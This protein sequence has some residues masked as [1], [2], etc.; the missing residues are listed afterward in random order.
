VNNAVFTPNGLPNHDPGF[1]ASGIRRIAWMLYLVAI[2]WMYVVAM[3]AVAEAVAPQGTLLG[4]LFTVL[5]WGVLPL[6]IVVYILGTPTRRRAR[7]AA[8]S[9]LVQPDSSGHAAGEAVAPERKET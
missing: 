4:A 7:R 5:G 3:V 1:F 8:E 6:A 9:A 2:G